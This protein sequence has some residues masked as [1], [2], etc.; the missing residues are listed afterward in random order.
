VTL[1]PP[2]D[3]TVN[4]NVIAGPYLVAVKGAKFVGRTPYS[5][6]VMQVNKN[7]EDRC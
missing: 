6:L 5:E 4:T 2:N 1:N 7:A 3:G